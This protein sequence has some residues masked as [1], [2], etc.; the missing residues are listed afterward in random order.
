LE[1]TTESERKA[2]AE[3]LAEMTQWPGFGAST[4]TKILHKKKPALTPILDNQAIFGA[5]MNPRWPEKRSLADTI[6]SVQR[7]N[8]AVGKG[9]LSR[10]LIAIRGLCAV[11]EVGS[12]RLHRPP[13]RSAGSR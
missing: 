6:K 2:L 4:V 12:R 9:W 7:I 11:P 13:T 5:Y 10:P 3:V 1:E 8:L